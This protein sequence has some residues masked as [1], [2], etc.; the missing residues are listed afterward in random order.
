MNRIHRQSVS[1]GFGSK[2][3]FCGTKALRQRFMNMNYC[4]QTHLSKRGSSARSV[5][6]MPLRGWF[7]VLRRTF[8]QVQADNVFLIS[9]GVA[10]FFLL[11]LAP[12]LTAFSA[13]AN[14]LIPQAAVQDLVN[15]VGTILPES[16]SQLIKD[17]LETVLDEH[18]R[19]TAL[20]LKAVFGLALSFWAAAA[21]VRAMMT[22]IT[23]AYR[24]DEERPLWEF[25]LTALGLTIAALLIGLVAVIA[26][27]ALP[28]ALSLLPLSGS[29]ELI[30][31]FLR[32]PLLIVAVIA[33]L[34]ITY[35][36]APSRRQ[37]KARWVTVG[38][39]A[40]ALMWITGS[41][42]FTTYV[43]KIA[44]YEEIHGALSSIVVLLL[45]FWF[46]AVVAI[47][48]A[49]LNA[50]LEHQTSVDTTVGKDHP[51]GERGAY[52]ADHLALDH[53]A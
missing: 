36:F 22:A 32:W 30:A 53:E 3:R 21:A 49:E 38:A 9:A 40:A 4:D 15:E 37:A 17:Q 51:M 52:V 24:E 6:D 29:S 46:S 5:R 25:H 41:L 26:F 44:N 23:V 45:W 18:E 27:L 1:Q 8:A 20:T 50:E 16:S 42:L 33:G 28:V 12:A 2:K 35:R 13:I 47:F 14:L 48:G 43:E 19:Q 39:V 10:F 31:R 34:S 11:A 7:D